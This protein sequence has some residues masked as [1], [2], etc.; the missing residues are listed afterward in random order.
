MQKW[1]KLLIAIQLIILGLFL[2]L[3]LYLAGKEATSDYSVTVIKGQSGPQGPQGIAGIDGYTPIKGV[4]YNDGRN[5]EDGSN[6]QHGQSIVGPQG[7]K[8]EQ[9]KR[10]E[11]GDTGERGEPGE[12]GASGREIE[13]RCRDFEDTRSSRV[14]YRYTGESS[15]VVLY[16]IEGKCDK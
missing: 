2:A 8:G 1:V 9:G 16:E 7:D 4:D 6:G 3:V 5:G 11:K 13:L 12:P 14:E 10:G 15:W